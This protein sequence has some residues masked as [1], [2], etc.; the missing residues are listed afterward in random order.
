MRNRILLLYY[1]FTGQFFP[2]IEES[3]FRF[4]QGWLT[5]FKERYHITKRIK[6]GESASADPEAVEKGREDMRRITSHYSLKDIYNMDETGLFYKLQPGKTLS[7]K[8]VSGTKINKDRLTVAL[9]MNADGTDK[10]KPLIINKSKRPRS[11][12]KIFNPRSISY[13]YY[14]NPKAWMNMIVFKHWIIELNKHMK[15]RNKKI[16]LL[17]DNASGHN[18]SEEVKKELTNIEVFYFEPNCT[19][20]IQPADA[21]IIKSFKNYYAKELVSFFVN[22]IDNEAFDKLVMPD[23][24]QCMYMIKYSW[25][26]VSEETIVN[27]WKKTGILNSQV[28]DQIKDFMSIDISDTLTLLDYKIKLLSLSRFEYNNFFDCEYFFKQ[29][30]SVETSEELSLSE[31]YNIVTNKDDSV[32]V[33]DESI[34]SIK[35]EEKL[36]TM[37]EAKKA[38]NDL[39]KFFESKDLFDNEK[40]LNSFYSIQ[41]I[42]HKLDSKKIQ[43]SI[44]S[45][46][47]KSD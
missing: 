39:F 22:Q 38:Y 29:I 32:E 45:F 4:S 11:F 36:M 25:S 35:I 17:V 37:T 14:Y 31:I 23:V 13:Y 12:G 26:C 30:D 6:H 46:L 5:K 41:E 2:E 9:C 3:G 43:S 16:A 8:A 24:K 20:H 47:V 18:L 1:V 27:C 10:L 21:G 15:S 19:S 33:V 7:D 40:I 44:E 42:I 34:E 28:D